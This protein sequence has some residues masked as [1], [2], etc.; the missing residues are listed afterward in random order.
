[1]VLANRGTGCLIGLVIQSIGVARTA[2]L[3]DYNVD[4]LA[5]LEASGLELGL[6]L[7]ANVLPR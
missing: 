3:C 7:T 5:C 4:V 6:L 1:M 2:G